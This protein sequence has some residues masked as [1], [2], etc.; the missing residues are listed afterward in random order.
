MI[1]LCTK[2]ENV[3]GGSAATVS[4]SI[5]GNHKIDRELSLDTLFYLIQTDP[6]MQILFFCHKYKL[7]LK[8]NDSSSDEVI[9][10]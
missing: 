2:E 6:G 8:V 4:T 1:Y 3:K 7:F 10:E 9:V 5:Q